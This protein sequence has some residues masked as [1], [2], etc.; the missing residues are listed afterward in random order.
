VRVPSAEE[1]RA[2]LP[3]VAAAP[4][5]PRAGFV[6]LVGAGPGDPG[7]LTVRAAARLRAADAVVFD[8]LAE[9]ALPPD[10]PERV[11][12]YPVGK[13]T[14]SHAV[15]QDEIN[16]LLVR[17]GQEGK[18]VVRFKGGDPFV[19]GRGAEEAE[20]LVASG[21]AYE[22][23]PG[24]TAGIAVPAYAGI[25]VT[26]RHE[27]NRVTFATAHGCAQDEESG[28]RW[29]L[30]AADPNATLVAYMGVAALRRVVASLLA[31]GM[32]PGVRG[33]VIERGTT[34][35]QRV[36]HAPL[37]E[38]A[39]KAEA[40]GVRPPALVVIGPT[41]RHVDH[42]D[43]FVARPLA[44]ERLAAAAPAGGV[45]EALEAAGAEVVAVPVPL[46]PAGR[47]VLGALPL[48]GCILR[49]PGE[50]EAFAA[51]VPV[52]GR[53][54]VAW[55]LGEGTARRARSAGWVKVVEAAAGDG[56]RNLIKAMEERRAFPVGS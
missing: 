10:L 9:P 50:A 38:L 1:E 30:L 53:D 34:A 44:G 36:V 42:L 20:A 15:P 56:W 48:T 55:C 52:W 35:A 39:V 4:V 22:I 12:L 29:D 41:V 13:E 27:A 8:R 6:S 46:T 21:V 31:A 5:R 7:L 18:R 16:A 19:F 3:A 2:L 49:A 54:A 26:S 45:K 11:E 40:A 51:E 23:V 37:A 25:P 24:V 28:A 17:L 33:A 32:D 14:G 47:I 43:W